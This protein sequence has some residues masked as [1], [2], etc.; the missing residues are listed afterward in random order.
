MSHEP[1]RQVVTSEMVGR[2]DRVVQHLTGL[3]RARVR[4]LFDHDCV[5]VNGQ[6]GYRDFSPVQAGDEVEVRFDPHNLPREKPADW[7]DPAFTLIY[8]DDQLL[9]VDKAAHVLTVPTEEG[10]RKTLL[11]AVDRYLQRSGRGD[12]AQVMQRLDRGTSGVLVLAK[13][14]IAYERLRAQFAAHKPLRE[15]LAIVA[16]LLPKDK[17]VFESYLKTGTDLSRYSTRAADTGGEIA[18]TH[19]QVEL[20]TADLTLVRCQLETGRRNQIRVHF[21]EAGHPVLGDPRYRPD[22]AKHPRWRAKRL[23]LHAAVLEFTHPTTGKPMHFE[24]PLPYAFTAP[25]GHPP[26]PEA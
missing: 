12:H 23:A 16:G 21:A 17:G 18:I 26:R 7:Q 5:R 8:E 3:S 15:Y 11:E 2:V 10:E 25:L 4:A 9:V 22:Q 24:S 14:D 6:L 13:T 1:K 19:Y 20:R